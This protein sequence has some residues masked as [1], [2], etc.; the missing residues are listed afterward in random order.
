VTALALSGCYALAWLVTAR[1]LYARWRGR[2]DGRRDCNKH[3]RQR[4]RL[5][6]A[7]C[8]YDDTSTSDGENATFAMLGAL[9]WPV[10]LVTAVVRFRPPPTVAERAEVEAKLKTRIAELEREAGV[11]P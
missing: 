11:T 6:S 1:L 8:C 7:R 2:L 9:F 4:T 3:G 5:T 10:V